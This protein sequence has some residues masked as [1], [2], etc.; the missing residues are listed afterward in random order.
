MLLIA[1]NNI[2]DGVLQV[3][4]PEICYPASGYQLSDTRPIIAH[5]QKTLAVPAQVFTATGGDRIEQVL[6]WT[7]VAKRFP[8]SW[9]EQR[10]AVMRENLAGE[11]PDGALVR[12][13][14]LGAD[15]AEAI[16]V[17]ESFMGQFVAASPEPL[18]R[19]LLG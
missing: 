18:R 3:H 6:Y 16:P 12:V 17:L 15:Q 7:R 5:L 4:R 8:R 13:S 14:L 2:Q 10:M 9:L 19:V 11:V 1:Y